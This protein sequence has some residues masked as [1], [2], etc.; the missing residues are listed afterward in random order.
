MDVTGELATGRLSPWYPQ[1]ECHCDAGHREDHSSSGQTSSESWPLDRC[2]SGG[3][4]LGGQGSYQMPGDVTLVL[5]LGCT[6]MR[7]LE[8]IWAQDPC[9]CQR[10]LL[11]LGFESR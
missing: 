10:P 7:K 11:F 9:K 8:G 2:H 5:T 4:P 1:E 6:F 3:L